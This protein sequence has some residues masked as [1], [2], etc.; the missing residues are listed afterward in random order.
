MLL[1]IWNCNKMLTHIQR[2][3][4]IANIRF[5]TLCLGKRTKTAIWGQTR[6]LIASWPHKNVYN[7]WKLL[8]VSP[9]L[10]LSFES[11]S[12]SN[13][14]R[15]LTLIASWDRSLLS[16]RWSG[17]RRL[18]FSSLPAGWRMMVMGQYKKYDTSN[19]DDEGQK[20]SNYLVPLES[21][22][23]VGN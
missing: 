9:P 16:L 2:Q 22:T 18:V 3:S 15:T 13:T 4:R 11:S 6:N 14:R 8:S 19:D 7:L 12:H 23:V 10:L 21:E 1:M 17:D 20:K 5:V